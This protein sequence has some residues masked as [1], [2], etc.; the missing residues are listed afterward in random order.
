[1]SSEGSSLSSI[2]AGVIPQ[3][4]TWTTLRQAVTNYSGGSP[5]LKLEYGKDGIPVLAKGDIKQFGRIEH[6]GRFVSP[7]IAQRRGY[8][9]TKPGDFLLTTRDLTQKAN[10]LGLFAPVPE[11]QEF[12]VN[13]GANLIRLSSDVDGRF[14]V[15]WCNGPIYRSYVK[16]HYVGSTQIHI[17]KD[18]FLDAPLLIPPLSEQRAIADVLSAFDDKIDSN[19]R[20]IAISEQAL[21]ARFDREVVTEE[22]HDTSSAALGDVLINVRDVRQPADI[23]PDTP[24]VGLEHLV[25]GSVIMRDCGAAADVTSG[26]FVFQHGDILFGKLRPYFRKVAF[27]SGSGVCSSDILV[28]RPLEV[29]WLPFALMITSSQ[30]FIDYCD[31][32]SSGTRM[33]RVSWQDMAAYSIGSPGRSNWAAFNEFAAPLLDRMNAAAVESRRLSALRDVLL[34]PLLSGELRIRNAEALAGGTM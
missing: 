14:I 5:I 9:R 4:W 15:Y 1:M 23:A 22:N 32:A 34:P 19:E 30:E 16:T 11:S 6:S 25:R 7:E 33:P 26:K 28:L 3:G 18:D 27:A 8:R 24:Y 12:I 13:Q 10:F 17:R 20:V 29:G 31:G 21:R 2:G